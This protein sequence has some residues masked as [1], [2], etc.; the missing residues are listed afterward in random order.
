MSGPRRR[1]FLGLGAL[2]A[3]AAVA[4]LYQMSAGQPATD[5]RR[6]VAP[7]SGTPAGSGGMTIYRDPDTGQLGVPPADVAAQLAP[8]A[9]QRPM[10]ERLG[11]TPGGGVLLDGG[12]LMAV[13]ATV[14][15]HGK[16]SAR[17]DRDAAAGKE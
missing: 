17:C 12:P 4:V 13:T 3:G 15:E 11:T 9:A 5:T 1:S 16:V 2:V 8:R 7:V 6:V 14:D 10:V